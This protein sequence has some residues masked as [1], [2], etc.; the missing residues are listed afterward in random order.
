MVDTHVHL[1]SRQFHRD[2]NQVIARAFETGNEFLVEAATDLVTSEEAVKL[3]QSFDRIY[4]SVG[5]HPHDARTVNE[6]VI[7]Q[8]ER[9]AEAPGVVAIGEVGLDYY[10]NLS[11]RDVQRRVFAEFIALARKKKLPL[12]VHVRAAHEDALE[13]LEKESASEVGGVLHCFSGDLALA[14]RALRLGFLLGFGGTITYEGS[15]SRRTV[16]ALPLD[17]LVLETDCPYLTPVPHRGKRNEPAYV[18]LVLDAL[19]A[20]KRMPRDEVDKVTTSNARELF[21][22]SAPGGASPREGTVST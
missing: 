12:I 1:L 15:Q 11:P 22:I 10:R 4:A 6:K 18:S 17:S 21:R 13:I 2:R 16:A 3:A 9:L 7:S 20:L 8:M 14:E 5:V 19:A